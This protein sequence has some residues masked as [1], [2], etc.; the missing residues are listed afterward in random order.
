MIFKGE[1]ARG[2]FNPSAC[3]ILPQCSKHREISL[4]SHQHGSECDQ[5]PAVPCLHCPGGCKHE[6]QGSVCHQCRQFVGVAAQCLPRFHPSHKKHWIWKDRRT[7]QPSSPKPRSLSFSTCHGESTVGFAVT[8]TYFRWSSNH[9]LWPSFM[10]AGAAWIT[11]SG[12][13]RQL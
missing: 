12:S 1:A 2:Q 10:G 5:M 3:S 8:I 6:G 9:C 7:G 4:I 13:L 11:A